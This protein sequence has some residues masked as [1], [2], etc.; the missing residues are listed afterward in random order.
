MLAH[1]DG[2][3]NVSWYNLSGFDFLLTTIAYD[4]R[5]QSNTSLQLS[6]NVAGLP[7]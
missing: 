5:F 6:Y 3:N 2:T 1:E 7:A 4:G